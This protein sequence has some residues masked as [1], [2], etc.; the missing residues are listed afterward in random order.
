[1]IQFKNLSDS[2]I[3]LIT[4]DLAYLDDMFEYSS[5]PRLYEYFEFA[6]QKTIA[7]TRIYLKDLIQRSNN[8]T[9]HWWHIKHKNDSKVIGTIGIHDI[10]LRRN[11]CEIS[12]ALSPNYWGRGLFSSAFKLILDY[13]INDICI[14]RI[15]ALTAENNIRSNKALLKN[16]FVKE[17]VYK[18]YYRSLE[19][20][21]FNATRY[22]LLI[23]KN[24]NKTQRDYNS[25]KVVDQN[26]YNKAELPIIKKEN[27]IALNRHKSYVIWFTGLSGS[28]KSTL[29]KY[30]EKKLFDIKTHTVFLDG[31]NLRNSINSDLGFSSYDRSENIRR[32][33]QLSKLFMDSGVVV[34]AAFISPLEKDRDLTKKNI[35]N[36]N[37]IEVYCSCSLDV[38][39]KRDPKGLYKK[40]LDGKIGNFTGIGSGY[41]I[42]KNPCLTIH[43]DKYNVESCLN[44][45]MDYLISNKYISKLGNE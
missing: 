42:P 34:L 15:T 14:Y 24:K 18:D 45:I 21:Y 25:P 8:V 26:I 38:C 33:S 30:L 41:E 20:E 7:E 36:D 4:L 1:M 5:D 23:D 32:A 43:T 27:K 40:V 9:A 11:S 16:N 44:Q 35:G 29:A 2:Y 6:P 39:K 13:L 31:D 19:G 37:F 22:S 17:G 10:D 3:E 12:Y 28:G